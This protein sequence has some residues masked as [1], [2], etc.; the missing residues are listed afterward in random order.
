MK[1]IK[2]QIKNKTM[3]VVSGYSLDLPAIRNRLIPFVEKGLEN[4]FKISL[5]SPTES[6][7][8]IENENLEILGINKITENSSSYFIR[9]INEIYSC[10]KMMRLVYKFK[11]DYVIIG[12]P[13]IFNLLFLKKIKSYQFLDIRDISWEYL[14]NDNFF[15]RFIKIIFRSI[16]KSK[17]KLFNII[18]TTNK[19]ES[20]YIKSFCRFPEDKIYLLPNGINIERFKQL[21]L[22]NKKVPKNKGIVISYI[23]NVGVAQ[24][25]ETLLVTAKNF[26]NIKFNIVGSGRDFKH[27]EKKIKQFNLSNVKLHGRVNWEYIKEIYNNTDILYAQLT[28]NFYSAMPSKL[29]EYLSSGK[30]IIYGGSGQAVEKLKSFENVFIIEPQ[31]P[32]ILTKSINNIILKKCHRI[33]S[34]YNREIIQNQY[35]REKNIKTFFEK[36]IT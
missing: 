24:N 31:N 10:Y 20:E 35:I 28:N 4:N 21:N 27:I 1:T 30:C 9:A 33:I 34:S 25:L 7:L 8:G 5:I 19:Y 13:S 26:K 14:S 32:K 23:G 29:Y 15:E 22:L 3:A 11:Y 2:K 16:S 18:I 12:I 36:N 17:F 6:E